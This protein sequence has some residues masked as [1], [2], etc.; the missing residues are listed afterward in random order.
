MLKQIVAVNVFLC[1]R[2]QGGV[3]G[4][5]TRKPECI[6]QGKIFGNALHHACTVLVTL[7][8]LDF[9]QDR[10]TAQAQEEPHIENIRDFHKGLSEILAFDLPHRWPVVRRFHSDDMK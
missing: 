9:W 4:T 7:S 10:N 2:F 6:R 3:K 1:Y 5:D 8:R